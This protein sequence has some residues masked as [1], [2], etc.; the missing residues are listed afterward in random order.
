MLV[1]DIE[2]DFFL[3]SYSLALAM[4]CARCSAVHC[5]KGSILNKS[6]NWPLPHRAKSYLADRSQT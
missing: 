2:Y 1:Y 4:T 5:V 6:K 3:Y